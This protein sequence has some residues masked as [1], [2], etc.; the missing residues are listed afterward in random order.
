MPGI[1]R[2]RGEIYNL[3]VNFYFLDFWFVLNSGKLRSVL[4]A[5]MIFWVCSCSPSPFGFW[6]FWGF[7][8]S[9]FFGFLFLFQFF[10]F[11][12]HLVKIY[13]KHQTQKSNPNFLNIGLN[14]ICW[15]CVLLI[16]FLLGFKFV[17]LMGLVFISIFNFF[18]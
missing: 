10:P 14:L 3:I 9:Y 6:I 18:I 7:E 8:F 15:V 1:Y 11:F 12:F 16:L 5:L 4:F 17:A 2:K 13:T